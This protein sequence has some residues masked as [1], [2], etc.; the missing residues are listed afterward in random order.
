MRHY[1]WN[2]LHRL[3]DRQLTTLSLLFQV[4]N[5]YSEREDKDKAPK[6][7]CSNATL[8]MFMK[9]LSGLDLYGKNKI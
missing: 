3:K 5:K 8:L 9:D 2:T 6:Q 4:Q 7:R 1:R